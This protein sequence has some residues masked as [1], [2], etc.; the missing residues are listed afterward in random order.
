MRLRNVKGSRE[1]IVDSLYTINE[2][3][4]MKGKWAEHF[5][6]NHPIHIEV[7]MGKE[8]LLRIWHVRIPILTMLELKSIPVY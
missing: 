4:F 6:N 7:G 1:A 3:A 8:R 2:P 5:G